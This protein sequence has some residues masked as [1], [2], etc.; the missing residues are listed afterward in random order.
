MTP[1]GLREESGS[2]DARHHQRQVVD[3]AGRRGRLQVGEGEE[4][5]ARQAGLEVRLFVFQTTTAQYRVVH[6]GAYK[7]LF[8]SK[9][10][11]HHSTLTKTQL[12][13]VDVS[14]KY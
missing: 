12:F 6:Q 4:G 13:R 3:D 10:N 9:Q 1:A 14:K 7:L 2:C 5:A 8:A 11:F